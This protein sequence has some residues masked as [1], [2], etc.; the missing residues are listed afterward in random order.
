M[1]KSNFNKINIDE[2]Y[3]LIF[4]IETFFKRKFPILLISII[5]LILGLFLTISK[6]DKFE[7]KYEFNYLPLPDSF[8]YEEAIIFSLY[9]KNFFSE[10]NYNEW[11]SDKDNLKLDYNFIL[12]NFYSNGYIYEK[13]G[14]SKN[15]VFTFSDKKN[16]ISIFMDSINHDLINDTYN[17]LQFTNK[18]TTQDFI[19]NFHSS[20]FITEN[21]SETIK[22]K[23]L[24]PSNY[25]NEIIQ[26]IRSNF[27]KEYME[28]SN[29]LSI[30]KPTFPKNITTKN[31]FFSGIISFFTAFLFSLLFFLLKDKFQNFKR[32]KKN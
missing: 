5:S 10:L 12:N 16:Y 6:E 28:N 29:I 3:E 22:K 9:E 2:N 24:I 30:S 21:L 13:D 17:Y 15:I 31:Y 4:L 11:A 25:Y 23:D 26:I 18:K 27:I 7:S 1:S 20:F 19:N 14:L 8:I 32:F